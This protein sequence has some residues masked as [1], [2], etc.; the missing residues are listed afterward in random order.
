MGIY[1]DMILEDK[2]SDKAKAIARSRAGI[3]GYFKNL[4]QLGN[5]VKML[6]KRPKGD[7]NKDGNYEVLHDWLMNEVKSCNKL[8]RLDYLRKDAYVGINQ[9]EKLA[10]NMT[11]VKAGHPSRYVSVKYIEKIMASGNSPA[12][13]RKHITWM[14]NTYLPAIKKRK[15]ELKKAMDESTLI[16]FV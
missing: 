12:K 16:D 7:P 3:S 5:D 13:V 10:K 6:S 14:K 8:D 1:Y 4:G 2:T 11:D 9:L 15:A